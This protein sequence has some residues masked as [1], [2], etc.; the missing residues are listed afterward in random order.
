QRH[1][2]LTQGDQDWV[3][4]YA[5][6]GQSYAVEVKNT[7][8]NNDIIIELYSG[9]NNLRRKGERSDVTVSL[10]K[11]ENSNGIGEDETLVWE[12]VQDDI[13]YV[14]VADINDN[15]GIDTDYDLG[16]SRSGVKIQGTVSGVVRSA[17]SNAPLEGVAVKIRCLEQ[18]QCDFN[19]PDDLPT[20]SSGIY[21]LTISG[22]SVLTASKSGYLV[23]AYIIKTE[24]IIASE[25]QIT[26]TENNQSFPVDIEMKQ[27]LSAGDI[28]C[29][30]DITPAD[31]LITFDTYFEKRPTTYGFNPDS[32]CCDVNKDGHCTPADALCIFR[33]Y[34]G[35]PGCL[36]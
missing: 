13:L 14:K 26:I 27:C 7:G 23:S 32:I 36:D 8:I 22:N 4:F 11:T 33:K 30:Q 25:Y 35:S 15:Y 10:L 12:A 34:L 31:A 29:D 17:I 1:S 5:V 16:V 28:N 6:A 3:K 19:N 24:K 2:F 20:E 21:N 18:G 9:G